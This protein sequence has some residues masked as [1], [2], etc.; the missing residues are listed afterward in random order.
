MND[1]EDLFDK[2]TVKHISNLVEDKIELLKDVKDFKEKEKMLSIYMDE[3]DE[4]LPENL[5]EKFDDIIRLM[6]QLEQYYFTLAYMLGSKYEDK[7]NKI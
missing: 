7:K 6:Y 4:E 5:K 1:V 2:E 3:I